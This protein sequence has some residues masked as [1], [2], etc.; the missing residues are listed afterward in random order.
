[1]A[2][3][4]PDDLCACVIGHPVKHSKSPLMHNMWLQQ[5]GIKGL[6]D[7]ID[8]TPEALPEFMDA[9]RDSHV[10]GFNATIPHKEKLLRLCDEIDADAA[11]IGAVNSVRR[12]GESL[13]GGN[14]DAYGFIQ[15][16]KNQCPSFD[17]TAGP[18]VV[19]GAGGAARAVLYGLQQEGVPAIYL[20]NRTYERATDLAQ[21]SP[22]IDAV[23]WAQKED[24][25]SAA[26]LLVNTTAL[27]M[28]GQP[29][30]E[31]SLQQCA[32]ST[33]VC[34]IVY[35]PLYTPLLQEAK[36]R[37]CPT[38]TGLGMLVEQGRKSFY[39]WF[40]TLPD[41]SDSLLQKLQEGA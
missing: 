37:H 17:F 26:N 30:L 5:T 10:Q 20:S 15:N 23:E 33:L 9:V 24:I 34:D 38:V 35:T 32:K 22:L 27:G 2:F 3:T 36:D 4:L 16:I 19:L 28:A 25:L 18:A 7:A 11:A 31:L 14:T 1:M 8:V 21:S 29:P 13:I 12:H 40:G 41:A 39:S 6:Y